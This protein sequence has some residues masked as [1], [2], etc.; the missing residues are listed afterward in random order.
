MITI[1]R[2]LIVFFNDDRALGA[3]APSRPVWISSSQQFPELL[4]LQLDIFENLTEQSRSNCFPCM[5]RYDGCPSIRM[6]NE[7]MAA[8]NA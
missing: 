5:N 1:N 8:L 3:N 4:N 7:M 2:R 6:L